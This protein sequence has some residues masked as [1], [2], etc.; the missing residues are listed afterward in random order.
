MG[1]AVGIVAGVVG[2]AAM[3]VARRREWASPDLAGPAVLALALGSYSAALSFGGNGFVAAF[4][5]GLAFGGFAGRGGAKEVFY[6]EQTAGLASLLTWLLFGAVAVPVVWQQADWQVALY[7]VLSLTL[8]RM[9][10][11]A[12][13]LL[14][15]GLPPATVAFIGWFG[16]RGLASVIFALV[17]LEDLHDEAEL[18][19]A[20]IATTV[21]L[22]V[23][24]HGLS[25]KP[26]AARYGAMSST[27]SH[28]AHSGGDT[29]PPPVRGLVHR[30]ASN[31][32][33]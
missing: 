19:V 32:T 27:T 3:R 18:A 14:G 16:P 11:V 1:L 7:A 5:G 31:D 33:P 21:L 13:A 17:A 8:I 2:G 29:S 20:V 28:P 9:V 15:T 23:L 22:S 24:A 10:P 26:F 6:V 25:A 12:V 4:V 30:H